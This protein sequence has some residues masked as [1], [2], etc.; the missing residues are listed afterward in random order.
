MYRHRN[1]LS[2]KKIKIKTR[3]KR[4]KKLKRVRKNLELK[5]F[6]KGKILTEGMNLVGMM[7]LIILYS[8]KEISLVKETTAIT[9][10]PLVNELIMKVLN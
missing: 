5:T 1:L 10:Q 2:R 7:T 6:I 4:R 3:R 9:A 8:N